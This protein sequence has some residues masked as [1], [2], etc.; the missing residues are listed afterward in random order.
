MLFGAVGLSFVVLAADW[1]DRPSVL[2]ALA[3]AKVLPDPYAAGHLFH[4]PAFQL[5]RTST[6]GPSGGAAVL[7]ASKG[8]VPRG[9]LGQG[10][11]DALTH[12]IPHDHLHGWSD[13]IPTDR[14][15]YPWRIE[16]LTLHEPL[17]DDGDVNVEARLLD[18]GDGAN[19]R[20]PWRGPRPPGSRPRWS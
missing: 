19:P 1:P 3:G 5:L 17:P 14:A 16:R 6:G 2:P 12:V 15:A 10:L 13:A 18:V 11:L 4:G 20:S 8:A 7:D 9:A